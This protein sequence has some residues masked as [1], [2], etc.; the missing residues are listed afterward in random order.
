MGDNN[1]TNDRKEQG[2]EKEITENC[3]P[4]CDCKK[5]SGNTKVKAA[6]CLVVLL[7][8]CGIFVYKTTGAKQQSIPVVTETAFVAPVVAANEQKAE[9]PTIEKQEPAVNPVEDE[10]IVGVSLD[11]LAALNKVAMSQDAVFIFVTTK[12]L[13]IANKEDVDAIASARK[14]IESTGVKIGL[15]TLQSS[16]TDYANIASQVTPPCMLVMSKGKGA[17]SVS[18]GIT[19]DKILQAYVASSRAGACGPSGCGPSGCGPGY[20][21]DIIMLESVTNTL[22]QVA[23]Q[24]L[25]LVFALILGLVSAATSACCT[26]P[27]LGILVGYSGAAANDNRKAAVK[28]ALLFT[29]G[30]ILSLMII[31]GIAGFVGQVAQGVLGR[32]WKVFAGIVA[33]FLGLAAL[34]LLPFKLSLGKFEGVKSRLGKSSAVLAG[35]I[36]GGIVAASSLPCNPGIFIVIGAAVLQGKIVWATLMLA[37]FAIGFSLPLGAML[38][39]ISLSKVSL[40]AK[41]ADAAIRCGA[42]VVLFVAGFYFLLT[43]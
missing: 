14:K 18:G 40:A 41:G 10:K 20:S 36:L 5:P 16:S 23:S 7:A 39:G 43:F 15:Y 19:E 34:N 27:A 12:G 22:Q 21:K 4:G 26:L 25:G 13:N 32:Y 8:V 24:P 33:V 2:M 6:V 31:G 1:K 35:L 11:S 37:M 17:G 38:L 29:L 30:T 3:G 28:T 42:G 9:V